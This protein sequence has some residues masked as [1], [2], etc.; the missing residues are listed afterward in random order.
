MKHFK[1]RFFS[2]LTAVIILTAIASLFLK[3]HLYAPASLAVIALL[4]T[5]CVLWCTVGRLKSLAWTFAKAL[6]S[7]DTSTAFDSRSDDAELSETLETFNRLVRVFHSTT[8]ELNTRK[9][10]YD[11]IL[12]VMTHEMGNSISP[13]ISICSDLKKHPERY[14]GQRLREAIDLIDSRSK[15]I[16]RF[17]KAYHALTHIPQP[18]IC[19]I[20]AVDFIR[21]I[22]L[23]IESELRS[24]NLDSSVC[25]YN[26]A[27]TGI[28]NIDLDLMTQVMVNLIRNALDAVSRTEHPE[29]T[30]SLSASEKKPHIIIRDN[31]HGIAIALRD[32]LF[33]PF[34]TTKPD[35]TGIGL[36]LSRQ[37]VRRHGGDIRLF[38][39]P[40]KGTTIV[41]ELPHSSAILSQDHTTTT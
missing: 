38:S 9:L 14:E 1:A 34:I 16:N 15:G 27:D 18:E 13:I 41:I 4:V 36:Y 33:Q 8:M 28:L 26:V 39:K 31:G 24:R 35:G 19:S 30:V 5:C 22:K 25:R 3:N 12:K 2:L 23:I 11:R 40:S 7:G 21:H 10:Y 17:L 29:V 32:E 20:T 6:E 37:I